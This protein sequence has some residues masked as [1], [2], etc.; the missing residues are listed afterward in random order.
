[1]LEQLARDVTAWQARAVEFFQLLATTQDMNHVRRQ[2]QAM[3]SVRDAARLEQL[4]G[5]FERLEGAVDLVH[6]VDVRAVGGGVGRYNIPDVGVFLWPLGAQSTTGSTAVAEASDPA[7]RFRFHPLGID[8]PLV[9]RPLTEDELAGLAD[10]SSVPGR[11]SRAELDAVLRGPGAADYL[12][13]RS[14]RVDRPGSP[15]EAPE[16]L[17]RSQIVAADLS[18]WD[19]ALPARSSLTFFVDPVLGRMVASE[20]VTAPPRVLFHTAWPAELGGGEY[21]RSGSLDVAGPGATIAIAT[22]ALPTTL[23][24]LPADVDTIELLDSGRAEAPA[25]ITLPSRP[26]LEL[27]AV[28]KR[29]PTLV[30][31]QTL[32][33]VGAPEA[34]VTINGLQIAGAGL[35]VSGKL[36]LLRLRHC[37]LVPG[38]ELDPVTRAPLHPAEPSLVIE[39]PDTTVEIDDC[40]VGAIRAHEDA[41]V[42]VRNSIVDA[43]A[44]DRVAFA[45]PDGTS[46]GATLSV[47]NSTVFGQVHALQL[48]LA[49][50]SIF[51]SARAP[52]DP[53]EVAPVRAVRRQTGC[54]RF[55][56]MPTDAVVPRRFRCEP[57]GDRD[58]SP[59]FESTRFGDAAY[60]QLAVSCPPSIRRGAEDESEMGAFHDLFQP[61]R[62]AHLRG[63]LDEYLRFG[64]EVGI[65]YVR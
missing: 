62:E 16:I 15:A 12:Y 33:I 50:S 53:P 64:L 56:F 36:R 52:A 1:V 60:A 48:D 25:A 51:A 30:L 24:T 49:S 29:R 61:Q 18:S 17:P 27:R 23:V 37:T 8:T 6:N 4:G 26:F 58:V 10:P 38:L 20:D 43:T 54:V 45:G 3:V 22:A 31:G 35:R 21:E 9:N 7:R 44:V 2:S 32:Q 39:S 42:H 40:I 11:I 47:V 19:R 46:P 14:L 13:P 55:C 57:S 28:N 59:A 41:T 5:P 63:R 34:S 65:F